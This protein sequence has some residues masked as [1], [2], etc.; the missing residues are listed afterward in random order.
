[1]AEQGGDEFASAADADLVE[2]SPDVFLHRVGRQVQPIYD[3]PGRTSL[4][5]QRRDALLC[6]GQSVHIQ[7]Q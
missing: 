4:K 5:K 6:R 7:Q 2:R 1:L 3:L